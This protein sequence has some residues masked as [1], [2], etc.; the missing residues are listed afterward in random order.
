MPGAKSKTN[1]AGQAGNQVVA[2]TASNGKLN[3]GKDIMEALATKYKRERDR[4]A[5]KEEQRKEEYQQEWR[6][7]HRG[8]EPPKIPS[9][10]EQLRIKAESGDK[11][12]IV[13]FA[14]QK[15]AKDKS[16]AK[17]RGEAGGNA[18]EDEDVDED[19]LIALQRVTKAVTPD[20]PGSKSQLLADNF[21]FSDSCDVEK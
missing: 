5:L 14:K 4:K 19:P 13:A 8:Q 10:Y 17:K 20:F 9:A 7:A 11:V 18:D 6:K 2:L 21:L 16:N 15:A 1:V 12:A 3:G